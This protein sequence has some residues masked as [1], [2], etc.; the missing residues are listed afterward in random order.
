MCK[1]YWK[2]G[3]RASLNVF[4]ITSWHFLSIFQVIDRCWEISDKNLIT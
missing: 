1:T 3:H 2:I 4:L